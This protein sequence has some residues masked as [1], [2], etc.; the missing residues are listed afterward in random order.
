MSSP[1][2]SPLTLRT[3]ESAI[4]ESTSRGNS[5]LFDL[6]SASDAPR[7]LKEPGLGGCWS[8]AG[9]STSSGSSTLFDLLSA[10]DSPREFEEPTLGGCW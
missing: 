10:S 2:P 8:V 4:G 1:S 5:A 6:P 9:E 7:E 3:W